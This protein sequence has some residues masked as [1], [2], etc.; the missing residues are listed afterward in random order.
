MNTAMT[1]IVTAIVLGLMSYPVLSDGHC[2][3]GEGHQQMM[4]MME[5]CPMMGDHDM[6]HSEMM[7][8]MGEHPMFEGEDM[9]HSEMMEKVREMDH[10]EKMEFIEKH[11]MMDDKDMDHSEMMEMMNEC[12]IMGGDKDD[13]ESAGHDDHH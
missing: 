8:K 9:N 10:A 12:P 13:E 11:P 4:G 1:S 2:Q 5:E 6:D 7:E 3:D